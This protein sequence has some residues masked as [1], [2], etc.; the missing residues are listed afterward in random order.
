MTGRP[1]P[2][3]RTGATGFTGREGPAGRDGRPGT[4][5]LPGRPG[6][7][8]TRIESRWHY[9]LVLYGLLELKSGMTLC[10]L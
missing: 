1:G 7:T 2:F 6:S 9:F 4:D 8:G 5:G 3:G 10:M